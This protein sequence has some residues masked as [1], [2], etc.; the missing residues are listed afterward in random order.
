MKCRELQIVL[1]TCP[2]P[3][4]FND[5][6]YTH[7]STA[8][9]WMPIILHF[10]MINC[11]K[12]EGHFWGRGRL[13]YSLEIF[14]GRIAFDEVFE[15]HTSRF[16][17]TDSYWS[18]IVALPLLL[19]TK[20]NHTISPITFVSGDLTTRKCLCQF[21]TIEVTD[22]LLSLSYTISIESTLLHSV[23]S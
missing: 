18:I 17:N 19:S 9:F 15:S 13:W 1:I 4:Y 10:A 20:K 11:L 16:S 7:H 14:F 23:N 5:N 22:L 8:I 3:N 21:S 12:G 6:R 2:T